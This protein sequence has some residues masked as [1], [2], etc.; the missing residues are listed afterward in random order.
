M[1]AFPAGPGFLAWVLH[2]NLNLT[3]IQGTNNVA[4]H[5]ARAVISGMIVSIGTLGAIVGFIVLKMHQNLK[6]V[7]R[8][9]LLPGLPN[10]FC[11]R[12]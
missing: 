6:P 9:T 2:I 1:G 11:V 8:S 12:R 10:Y 4:S 7:I 5:T 3:N